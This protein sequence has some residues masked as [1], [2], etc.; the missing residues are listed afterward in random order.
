M[1]SLHFCTVLFWWQESKMDNREYIPDVVGFWR[2]NPNYTGNKFPVV[3]K[4]YPVRLLRDVKA[5][6]KHRKGESAWVQR[7]PSNRL[8]LFETEMSILVIL[9]DAVEGVDFEVL[10]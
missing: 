10:S 5:D 1:E 9:M 8:Y 7:L 3:F 4:P 6:R 2:R